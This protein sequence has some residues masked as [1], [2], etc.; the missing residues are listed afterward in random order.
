[1]FQAI[2]VGKAKGMDMESLRNYAYVRVY[3]ACQDVSLVPATCDGEL[4][5]GMYEFEFVREI[6]DPMQA[7]TQQNT[8][9]VTDPIQGLYVDEEDYWHQRSST[10]WLHK[11]DENT[12][13]FHRIANGRKKEEYVSFFT[14]WKHNHT[15][16]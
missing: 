12:T 7:R 3:I 13:Y 10:N 11:G 16:D 15:G 4:A 14:R 1:M 8:F 6:V 5:D 9:L 2:M